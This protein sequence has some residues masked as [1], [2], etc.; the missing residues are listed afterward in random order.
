MAWR[1]TTDH[2]TSV[3]LAFVAAL[4][5]PLME[6]HRYFSYFVMTRLPQ[7]RLEFEDS[8]HRR[9]YLPSHQQVQAV[10]L[11][12]LLLTFPYI[13]SCLAFTVRQPP[14]QTNAAATS[15]FPTPVQLLTKRES[16]KPSGLFSIPTL[17][18]DFGHFV[19]LL[20]LSGQ[21]LPLTFIPRFIHLFQGS[22]LAFVSI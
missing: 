9:L 7:F 11:V 3:S 21:P 6:D 4:Q 5:Q 10:V 14:E 15:V 13:R 1:S 2:W 22:I 12:A 8:I 17:L 20:P 18:F 19:R 16:F